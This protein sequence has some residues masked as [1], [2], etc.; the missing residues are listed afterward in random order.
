[1]LQFDSVAF[2]PKGILIYIGTRLVAPPISVV[3][4]YE[5][6]KVFTFRVLN[7]Y[8]DIL[9]HHFLFL[10]NNR[11]LLS[12][13]LGEVGQ[14]SPTKGA[15]DVAWSIDRMASILHFRA[16]IPRI[17]TTGSSCIHVT[18]VV[19]IDLT[20]IRGQMFAEKPVGRFHPNQLYS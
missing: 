3:Q 13:V 12:G 7:N 2:A 9:L 10:Y 8:Q 16:R 15:S 6:R 14:R 17:L 1:V 5:R 19:K 11:S 18:E 20:R 4:T